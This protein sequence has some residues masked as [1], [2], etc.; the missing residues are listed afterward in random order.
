MAK[1]DFGKLKDK[2][3]QSADAVM[4]TAQESVPDKMKN[5]SQ[6]AD[7]FV[8]SAQENLP[9]KMKNVDV[10]ANMKE[11]AKKS[12]EALAKFKKES[13]ETDRSVNE[14]L[15]AADN[16]VKALNI[17]DTL[18]VIYY[19]ISADRTIAQEEMN[20]FDSIGRDLNPMYEEHRAELLS[21]C[22]SEMEK[23][24]EEDDFSIHIHDCIGNAIRHS[25]EE[26]NGTVNSKLFLW[27]LLSVAYSDGECSEE[28]RKLVRYAGKQLDVD[29]AVISEMEST[30]NSLL[31]VEKE[32]DFVK[33][34]NRKYSEVEAIVNELTDRK[35][36]IMK[37][38]HAL[39]TD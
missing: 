5:L 1:L 39:I 34:S 36:V 3:S 11:M 38:I 12:T 16:A 13:E 7:T 10:A 32:I 15:A 35:A 28:E 18:K 14:A 2:I 22:Q 25:L 29:K 8:K 30:V 17:E 24:D 33:N 6:A 37:G 27:N 23:A 21:Y 4:K 26:G 31:A 19:L 9:E 20:L